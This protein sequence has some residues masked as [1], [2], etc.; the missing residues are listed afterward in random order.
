[1]AAPGGP[2]LTHLRLAVEVA[3]AGRMLLPAAATAAH[4]ANRAVATAARIFDGA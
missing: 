1:M 2:I 4:P 3:A